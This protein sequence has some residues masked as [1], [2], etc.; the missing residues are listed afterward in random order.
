GAAAPA[1]PGH[2]DAAMLTEDELVHVITGQETVATDPADWPALLG[3]MLLLSTT[4]PWREHAPGLTGAT[5]EQ[6]DESLRLHGQVGP[7]RV[8]VLARLS[9]R[10]LGLDLEWQNTTA[11]AVTDLAVGPRLPGPDQA[12]VT[13]PQVIYHDNPSAD[14]DRTVPHVSRGGFV[15]E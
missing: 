12:R 7:L 9:E 1:L 10:G 8:Q 6:V 14:P 3:R 13:I 15:T 2:P 5:I 4:R 11:E